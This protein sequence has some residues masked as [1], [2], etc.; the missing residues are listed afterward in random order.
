MT[1]YEAVYSQQPPLVISYLP[2]TSKV[3]V[4]DTLIQNHD[5]TLVTLNDNL[6]MAKNCLKQQEDQH[7]SKLDFAMRD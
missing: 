5:V 7:H 3:Q 2:G 6:T 1:P 4:V